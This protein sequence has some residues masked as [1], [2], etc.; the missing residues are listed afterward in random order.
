MIAKRHQHRKTES[1]VG[2]GGG[3]AGLGGSAGVIIVEAP[4]SRILRR[5]QGGQAGQR[6][7]LERSRGTRQTGS[8]AAE[9]AEAAEAGRHDVV[10]TSGSGQ[11]N[12]A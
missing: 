3:Q 7:R 9:A 12:V 8:A 11:Q 5:W 1:S 2:V 10:E 6:R 4:S